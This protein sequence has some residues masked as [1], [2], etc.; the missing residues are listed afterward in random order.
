MMDYELIITETTRELENIMNVSL[1][2]AAKDTVKKMMG[3]SVR[4]NM[5][6]DMPSTSAR[7][8]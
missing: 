6:S 1:G 2:Q 3:R 5:S 8:M 7:M 4:S